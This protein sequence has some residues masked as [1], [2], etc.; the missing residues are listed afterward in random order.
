MELK[1]ILMNF[2]NIEENISAF[3]NCLTDVAKNKK[4]IIFID[5]LDRCRPS[6]ALG[7]IEKIK[8]IFDI[9]GVGFVFFANLKQIEAMINKQYGDKINATR[10]L[11]KFFP[12]SIEL[13]ERHL[14]D[15]NLY[16]NNAFIL[17]KEKMKGFTAGNS[18]KEIISQDTM[19][20]GLFGFLFEKDN[21]VPRD[22]QRFYNRILICNTF[23]QRLQNCSNSLIIVMKLLG[24]YISIFKEKLS[25]KILNN[26]STD[27][28]ML[29]FFN[30]QKEDFYNP[31][32]I[33]NDLRSIYL[34][35]ENT[36][37]TARFLSALLI[38]EFPDTEL[39]SIAKP[40]H[41][42]I[43]RLL[44]WREAVAIQGRCIAMIKESIEENRYLKN[45]K[46]TGE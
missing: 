3:K 4:I 5:E 39:G 37:N 13:P 24:I 29:G 9:E 43:I 15:P 31:Q 14:G 26:N 19:G 23:D 28:D 36:K 46:A 30:M 1:N 18:S 20:E 33:E 45:L 42:E 25:Y 27:R 2:E 21:I 17:F 6:F 11:S 34:Y 40:F 38:S 22:A 44:H 16:Q 35:R 41:D 12:F 32:E 10:Y 8:H 7:I